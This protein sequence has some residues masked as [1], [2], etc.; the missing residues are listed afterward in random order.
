MILIIGPVVILSVIGLLIYRHYEATHISTDDAYI[1]GRI[2]T[3][4]PKIPGTVRTVSVTDNQP[5]RAGDLLVELDP[6]DYEVKVKETVSSVESEKMKLREMENRLDAAEKQMTEIRA[7]IEV[8]RANVAVQQANLAQA[9]LDLRRYENLYKQEAI[10]KERY[11]KTRTGFDVT[12]AQ[13]KAAQEH[14]KQLEASLATQASLARQA[15]AAVS[16][17]SAT[18]QNKEA[19]HAGA[20]LNRGYTRIIA[21][22]D[23]HVTKKSVEKGNQVAPGTPLLAL[24]PLDDIWI[25]ANYKE[26]QLTRVK[27]GQRVEIAVDTYPG[28]KWQ[29]KVES[30]MAGTGSTFSLFPPENATGNYVKVVQRI[31]VKIILDKSSDKDRVL[32][33]GMSVMSTIIIE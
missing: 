29:G 9:V 11:E 28:K 31:P 25:I 7:G 12:E 22:T 5:V 8:A 3:I 14:V 23:G 32:R 2:H 18:V 1:E 13:V 17:Q 20:L 10:S 15:R 4:A 26:T 33:I 19:I 24:V 27:T 30:I 6:A 16:T 21:P